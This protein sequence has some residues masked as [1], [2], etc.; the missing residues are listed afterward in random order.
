MSMRVQRRRAWAAL[1][2]GDAILHRALHLPEGAHLDRPPAFARDAELGGQILERDWIIGEPARLEDA[3]FAII[4]HRERLAKRL[5]AV[6]RLL[7]RDQPLLLIRDLVD[8]P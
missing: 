6:V 2:R 5:L 3:P 1:D 7:V 8:Q 4:E